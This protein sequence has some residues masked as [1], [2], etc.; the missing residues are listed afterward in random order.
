MHVDVRLVYQ[1]AIDIHRALDDLQKIPRQGDQAL[2]KQGVIDEAD[3]QRA[4]QLQAGFAVAVGVTADDHV[5]A[6]EIARQ[7]IR[8]CHQHDF[9]VLQGIAH[10]FAIHADGLKQQRAD[11]QGDNHGGQQR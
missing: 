3:L 4:A 5:A 11:Q 6:V 8:L 7:I 2:D 1:F 9:I 10:A